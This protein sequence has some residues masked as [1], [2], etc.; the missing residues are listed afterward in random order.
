MHGSYKTPGG[1]LVHVDFDLSDGRL[2]NVVV[3]GDFFLY[4]EE[5]LDAITASIE[6]MDA[7]MSTEQ[8]VI[9]IAQGLHPDTTWLGASPEALNIAI[10]RALSD[11]DDN[12]D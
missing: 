1:K 11:G 4:P 9:A 12:R 5:A 10:E 8:R 7:A 2:V 6:G 3:S